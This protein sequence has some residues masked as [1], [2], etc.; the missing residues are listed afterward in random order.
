MGEAKPVVVEPVR[1]CSAERSIPA[2]S[3]T[4]GA[5][6]EAPSQPTT[7]V[8]G[9]VTADAVLANSGRE[10]FGLVGLETM[11]AG[12]IAFTGSTGED[13]VV[14]LHN[15]IVLET[16]DPTEIEGYVMYLEARPYLKEKI[17][18]AAKETASMFTWAEVIKN[19]LQKLEYRARIQGLISMPSRKC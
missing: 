10:P 13:Y 14:P 4:P 9:L 2:R 5:A 3:I 18:I 16:S 15:A 1:L 19:L 12:G 7:S 17:R 8:S 11:A 6:Q